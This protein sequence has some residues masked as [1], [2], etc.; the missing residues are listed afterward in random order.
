MLLEEVF[1]FDFGRIPIG[2][3]F[4]LAGVEGLDQLR[5]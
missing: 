5:W 3:Y 2:H 4:V 1:G